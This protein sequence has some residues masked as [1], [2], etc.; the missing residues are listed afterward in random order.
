MS[1]LNTRVCLR[2]WTII[3]TQ[4]PPEDVTGFAQSKLLCSNDRDVSLS[5][6]SPEQKTAVLDVRLLFNYE[7]RRE[8][9]RDFQARLVGS[10]MRVAHSVPQE[11][12]LSIWLPL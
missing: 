9:A 5:S 12:V 4:D 3:K 11:R 2:F 10:H 1:L 8:L 6:L 7:P